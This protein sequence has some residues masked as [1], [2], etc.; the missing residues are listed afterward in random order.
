MKRRYSAPRQSAATPYKR[1]KPAQRPVS[2]QVAS[3][4]EKKNIDIFN[5]N[6]IA[7]ATATATPF[8][9]NGC[10]DGT[11]STTRIGRRIMMQSLNVR[12]VGSFAATTAGSSPLRCLIVYDKQSNAA[13]PLS[14][15]ILQ[16]D[17]ISGQMNLSNSRRFQILADE[18][19]D[20]FGAAGPTSFQRV[21][22]RDFTAKGTKPGLP[23]EFN[24]TSSSAI[25]AITTG[26][27]YALIY[28]N[29]NLI[30]AAPAQAFYSRIRF[31]DH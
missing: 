16:V 22:F 29:G 31:I 4:G 20:E 14:S 26:S 8:L 24:G 28:Q 10:D 3:L 12:W 1:F 13:A 15:D 6:A 27:V 17:D 23:V 5:T 18:T 7:A 19:I 11:T 9:L 30:T 25:T 21:F 2:R